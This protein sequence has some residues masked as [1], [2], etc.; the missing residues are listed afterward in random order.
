MLLLCCCV[1]LRFLLL[2]LLFSLC[3]RFGCFVIL[4]C[5]P[6]VFILN[7]AFDAWHMQNYRTSRVSDVWTATCLLFY[8]MN[9][10]DWSIFNR[11]LKSESV[12]IDLVWAWAWKKTTLKNAATD[13]I[14]RGFEIFSERFKTDSWEIL[15][16]RCRIKMVINC[17]L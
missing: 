7:S 9:T 16:V 14:D 3:V 11:N 2:L 5:L 15:P 6:S 12:T 8:I 10:L 1:S 13:W 17:E 4:T